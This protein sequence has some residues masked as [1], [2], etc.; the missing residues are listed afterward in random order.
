MLLEDTLSDVG[1]WFRAPSAG[2]IQNLK[3][4]RDPVA[5]EGVIRGP[6]AIEEDVQTTVGYPAYV[7]KMD[8]AVD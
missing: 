2:H 1:V 5:V 6:S 3:T 4:I 7:T 8:L